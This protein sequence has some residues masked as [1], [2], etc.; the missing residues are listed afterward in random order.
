MNQFDLLLL[1]PVG[2]IL[3]LGFAFLYLVPFILRQDK[4]TDRMQEIALAVKVGARAYLKKQYMGVS[5]FFF[6]VFF[7]LLV[8]AF[9]NYLVIFVPFAFI[10]GG[11]FS[12]LSGFI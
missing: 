11:F 10:T 7:I 4:G 6:V 8:M 2:S 5:L 9:K 3:A 12:G 1:A